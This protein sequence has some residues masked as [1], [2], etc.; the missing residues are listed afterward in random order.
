MPLARA[1]L[2][3]DNP[4]AR[5]RSS[6]TR[7]LWARTLTGP[8]LIL[9]CRPPRAGPPSPT[10]PSWGR[11]RTVPDL[12][13]GRLG[14]RLTHVAPP[15]RARTPL[16]RHPQAFPHVRHRQQPPQTPTVLL[17]DPTRAPAPH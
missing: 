1:P 9:V 4:Q 7:R 16:T 15:S 5:S 17:L 11:A 12:A 14:V 13:A 3:V 10:E 6:R 8:P 2:G